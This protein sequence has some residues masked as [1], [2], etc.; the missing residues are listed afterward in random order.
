MFASTSHVNAE[1]VS[2]AGLPR[3]FKY[4]C[5]RLDKVI[6]NGYNYNI[7]TCKRRFE[8]DKKL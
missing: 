4:Y 7:I 8:N 2:P 1:A 5:Y 6:K 3:K